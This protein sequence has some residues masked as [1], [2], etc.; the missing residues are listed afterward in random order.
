MCIYVYSSENDDGRK[1]ESMKRKKRWWIWKLIIYHV[2][3]SE[4]HRLCAIMKIAGAQET[5]EKKLVR[6]ESDAPWPDPTLN[7]STWPAPNY[8]WIDI[9]SNLLCS[10][11]NQTECCIFLAKLVFGLSLSAFISL[12][13]SCAI[14]IV[15][16][17][18]KNCLKTHSHSHTQYGWSVFDAFANY[19]VAIKTRM[20]FPSANLDRKWASNN[21][22]H[23]TRLH[24]TKLLLQ[25]GI[26]CISHSTHFNVDGK[27]QWR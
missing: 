25:F 22:A 18:Q 26:Q 6:C 4:S 14:A 27:E 23:N 10:D 19:S 8:V 24:T 13:L 3:C 1:A 15:E 11:T 21:M 2:E 16:Q 9:S 5:N 12:S 17:F 7:Y 20:F